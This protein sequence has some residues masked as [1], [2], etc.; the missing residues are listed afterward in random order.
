MKATL[1]DKQERQCTF[2][3][4][5]MRHRISIVAVEKAVSFTYSECVFVALVIQHAVLMHRIVICYLYVSTIFFH[6]IS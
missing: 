4:T 2:N 1:F 3:V 5:L 6:V